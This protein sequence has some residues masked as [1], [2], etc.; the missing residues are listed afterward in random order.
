[1]VTGTTNHF[2]NQGRSREGFTEYRL[3]AFFN[4]HVANK[5]YLM[6]DAMEEISVLITGKRGVGKSILLKII[7][8]KLEEMGIQVNV[9]VKGRVHSEYI[10]N[11][12]IDMSAFDYEKWVVNL[13]E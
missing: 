11:M 13:E 5:Y 12:K 10:K 7:Q 4:N 6:E 8:T 1:M 9:S 3:D 2:P